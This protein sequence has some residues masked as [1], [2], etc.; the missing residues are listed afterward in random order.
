MLNMLNNNLDYINFTNYSLNFF[1]NFLYIVSYNNKLKEL[2]IFGE[3]TNSE[4]TN[5]FVKHAYIYENNVKNNY[6]NN[7]KPNSFV[8]NF[9]NDFVNNNKNIKNYFYNKTENIL[10]I[11]ENKIQYISTIMTV[12]YFLA[13]FF[14]IFFFFF[15][16]FLPKPLQLFSKETFLYGVDS[17]YGFVEAEKEIGALDDIILPL[18]LVLLASV[19]WFFL[20]FPLQILLTYTSYTDTFIL[21]FF[22]ITI[23][24]LPVN[25]LYECGFFFSTFFRGSAGSTSTLMELVYDLIANTT[26]FARMQVQHVRVLLGLAMYIE[27]STYIETISVFEFINNNSNI[28]NLNF[29]SVSTNSMESS[30]NFVNNIILQIATLIAEIG[31]YILFL[32]QS[33]ASYAALIFWLFSLLYSGFFKDTLEIYFA[34]KNKK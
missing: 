34:V 30:L 21:L 31:H 32:L 15:S 23:V 12:V 6:V 26:M 33:S 2:Q 11:K 18:I 13:T 29:T 17:S 10:K 3:T 16:L 8:L 24:S 19:S 4:I 9:T 20:L 14:L 28:N 5:V 1:Y 25:L 27:T 7:N 22:C